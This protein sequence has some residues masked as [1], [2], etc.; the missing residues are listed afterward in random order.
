MK[1]YFDVLNYHADSFLIFF[2]R[3]TGHSL[4]DFFIGTFVLAFICVIV[5]EISVSLALKF[6]KRYIDDLTVE[7][8]AKEQLAL[9]AYQAGN[10][11]GYKALNKEATDAWG[12]HFF[13]MIAY[14]A[15]IL[16]PIPFAFG[17]LQYRFQEVAFPLAFPV[18]VVFGKTVG[19]TFTF[20][21][22][23]IFCRI[24]FKYMRP[25]LPYFRKVQKL[26]D[27]SDSKKKY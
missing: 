16:W 23:Y 5:G 25:W 11:A 19:Y 15:G 13:T 7:M 1:Y 22:L 8:K 24:I 21:P 2:Y 4:S 18:S 10:Q 12:K 9:A 26:L 14:S 27:E 3:I 20:I 6:N 17:W